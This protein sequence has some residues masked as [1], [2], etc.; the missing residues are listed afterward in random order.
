FCS[1]SPLTPSPRQGEQAPGRQDQVGQTG[2]DDRC[3]HRRGGEYRDAAQ[4]RRAGIQHYV[5]GERHKNIAGEWTYR[6][7]MRTV[8]G[9]LTVWEMVPSSLTMSKNRVVLEP[10]L[11]VT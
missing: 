4:T 10:L 7:R 5:A 9:R 2:T 8:A 11:P 6:D 1:S 3:G